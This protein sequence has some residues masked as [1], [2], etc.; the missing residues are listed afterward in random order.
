MRVPSGTPKSVQVFNQSYNRLEGFSQAQFSS[1]GLPVPLQIDSK[2]LIL[3][4]RSL[5]EKTCGQ[6]AFLVSR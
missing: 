4:A 1:R 3:V 6:P 5:R 2:D